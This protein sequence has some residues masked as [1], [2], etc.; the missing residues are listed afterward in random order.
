MARGGWAGMAAASL[1]VMALGACE[2]PLGSVGAS[3]DSLK[4]DFQACLNDGTHDYTRRV[5]FYPDSLTI[6][7]HAYAT[8]GT[9]C[10]GAQASVSSEI[11][12][13]TLAGTV[14]APIGEPAGTQVLAREMNLENSYVK[15]FTIV[16]VD[17]QATPARLYLGDLANPL[18]DGSAPDRRPQ[19]LSAATVLVGR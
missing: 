11:W 15:V 4:G 1:A 16:Y 2:P 17:E 10:G 6:I 13:Y 18:L 9:T 12:R 14:T 8:T 7:T 5:V 19:I 3:G